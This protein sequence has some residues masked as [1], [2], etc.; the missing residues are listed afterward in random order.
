MYVGGDVVLDCMKTVPES[1]MPVNAKHAYALL[2]CVCVCVCVC[3]F[4]DGCKH[5]TLFRSGSK[6]IAYVRS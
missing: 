3:V 2:A 6:S 1:E 4:V 5:H